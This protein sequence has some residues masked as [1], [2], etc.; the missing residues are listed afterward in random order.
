MMSD[1]VGFVPRLALVVR[2]R[3]TPKAWCL[4]AVYLATLALQGCTVGLPPATRWEV[5]GTI[6]LEEGSASALEFR[7][8]SEAGEGAQREVAGLLLRLPGEPDQEGAWMPTSSDLHGLRMRLLLVEVASGEVFLDKLVESGEFQPANWA[9]PDVG[10]LLTRGSGDWKRA[11]RR[12]RTYRLT[13]QV[14]SAAAEATTGELLLYWL[15]WK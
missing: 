15:E 7:M 10:Y 9:A 11:V 14:E 12:D 6:R 2:R 13:C 4:A 5:L 1:A 8:D 3:V